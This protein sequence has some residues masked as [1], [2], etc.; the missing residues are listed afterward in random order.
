[1]GVTMGII[2][3]M[4]HLGSDAETRVTPSGQ[5][6]TTVS[7]A[8]KVRESGQDETN[9]FRITFWHDRMGRGFEKALPYF[10]KG[11]GLIVVGE[12]SKAKVYKDKSQQ[13]QVSLNVTA[14]SFRFPP[15]G[16]P[17]RAQNESF[18][19]P[20]SQAA[21]T[22]PFN[23]EP[24]FGGSVPFTGNSQP[25]YGQGQLASSDHSEEDDFPF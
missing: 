13:D 5:K 7:I 6:V 4:G 10:K 3:V 17:D 21:P 11:S 14:E 1:M 25:V 20:F 18:S 2:V 19:Q 24:G 12:L 22:A 16:K 9:W 15:F 8:E 23:S